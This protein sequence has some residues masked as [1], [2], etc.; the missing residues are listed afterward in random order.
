MDEFCEAIMQNGKNNQQDWSGFILS[1]VAKATFVLLA[2]TAI[3]VVSFVD[4]PAG[5]LLLGAGMLAMT[6]LFLT[7]FDHD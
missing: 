2:V 7:H 1:M 5:L 4:S 3:I 6:A